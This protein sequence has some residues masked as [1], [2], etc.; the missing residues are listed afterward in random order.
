MPADKDPS[1]EN[2]TRPGQ[3]ANPAPG[4]AGEE[5]VQEEVRQAATEYFERLT[6]AAGRL[7]EQA[8]H[9]YGLSQSYVKEHPSGLLAGA[10]GVGVLLGMLFDRD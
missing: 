4:A 2:V 3:A 7:S 8:R 5:V 10:F 9:V 1:A 6:E